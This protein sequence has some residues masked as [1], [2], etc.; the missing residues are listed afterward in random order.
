MRLKLKTNQPFLRFLLGWAIV[1]LLVLAT[2]HTPL[3]ARIVINYS[4][5]AFQG[6]C[7]SSSDGEAGINS[8]NEAASIGSLVV[9]GAGYFL[10]AHSEVL[11]FLSNYELSELYGADYAEFREIVDRAIINMESARD[12]YVNLNAVAASTPYDEAFIQKLMCWDYEG[13]HNK[14][15]SCSEV[16]TEVRHYLSAG[17]VR[18]YYVAFQLKLEDLLRQLY[19]IKEYVD[20]GTLPPVANAW[21]LNRACSKTAMFGQHGA[22]VFFGIN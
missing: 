15:T 20:R 2:A 8:V 21:T 13:L 18:G 7:T 22:E 12:T 1:T 4:E 5:C 14:K 16:C 10:R 3:S 11:L 6:S 17:D 19:K 9:D